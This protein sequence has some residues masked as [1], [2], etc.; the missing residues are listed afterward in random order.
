[1]TKSELLRLVRLL[2]AL[3][4]LGVCDRR[5]PDY[6]LEDLTAFNDILERELLS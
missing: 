4:A 6:L 1:M 2:A 5:L 3:E